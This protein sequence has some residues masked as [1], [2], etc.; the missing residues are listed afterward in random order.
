M[1]GNKCLGGLS[2]WKNNFHPSTLSFHA[3]LGLGGN[4]T[5]V[6]GMAYLLR[7]EKGAVEVIHDHHFMG[8]FPKNVWLEL[9]AATG[10]KPLEVPCEHSS[11]NDT[12]RE[13]FLGMRP[14]GNGGA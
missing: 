4:C 9:I 1:A 5:Y 8:L 13:V 12:E 10:F 11:Y 6:T 2:D 14:V 3:P 7:D